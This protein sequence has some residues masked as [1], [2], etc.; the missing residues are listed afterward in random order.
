MDAKLIE[1]EWERLKKSLSSKN[2]DA[3][4]EATYFGFFCHGWYGRLNEAAYQAENN[5]VADNK[6]KSDNLRGRTNFMDEKTL[7][8]ISCDGTEIYGQPD[9]IS[10]HTN[11]DPDCG[12]SSWGM[13]FWVFKI[14]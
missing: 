3:E 10:V 1:R 4:Q 7:L 6:L 9:K 8:G 2:W 12:G 13:A 5:S 11:N 14:R